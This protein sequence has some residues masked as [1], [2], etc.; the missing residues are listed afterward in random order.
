MSDSVN[1][2]KIAEL[3]E[4]RL[5]ILEKIKKYNTTAQQVDFD[6]R[7]GLASVEYDGD[8]RNGKSVQ[9]Y[10]SEGF[11]Q[12]FYVSIEEPGVEGYWFPSDVN[13]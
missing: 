8:E 3:A 9:E 11:G 6:S 5:D 10:M 2:E 4:L 7:I 1:E 12:D 13:C